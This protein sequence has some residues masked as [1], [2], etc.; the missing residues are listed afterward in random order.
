MSELPEFNA[1]KPKAR[2]WIPRR[3]GDEAAEFNPFD[4]APQSEFEYHHEIKV[5][6]ALQG[7]AAALRRV[8]RSVSLLEF[9]DLK[10]LS[11]ELE[12]E[13]P[14]I[15]GLRHGVFLF[16]F[17]GELN[18]R[19][20]TRALLEGDCIYVTAAAPPAAR[21]L[22]HDALAQTLLAART[23]ANAQVS[24]VDL[25][26]QNPGLAIDAHLPRRS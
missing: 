10:R 12:G 8:R 20:L 23:Y 16:T 1:F 7:M 24:G 2:V 25:T 21:Q 4:T 13:L 22:A 17:S 6:Y 5:R 15:D 3:G 14:E 19:K 9:L 26:Q 18:R 11:P